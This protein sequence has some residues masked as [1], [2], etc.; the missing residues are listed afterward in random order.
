MSKN[1]DFIVVA[2]QGIIIR[3]RGNNGAK[4]KKAHPA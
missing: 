3:M 1:N 4:E 2:T